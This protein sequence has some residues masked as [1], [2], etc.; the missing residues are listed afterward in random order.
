MPNTLTTEIIISRDGK[1]II[2]SMNGVFPCGNIVQEIMQYTDA[3]EGG[4]F[5]VYHDASVPFTLA[6]HKI[7]LLVP[8]AHIWACQWLTD[9]A[10]FFFAQVIEGWAIHNS[11]SMQLLYE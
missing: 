10:Q 6:E 5:I 9:E 1:F 11:D 3:E 8:V 7:F 2:P 4:N